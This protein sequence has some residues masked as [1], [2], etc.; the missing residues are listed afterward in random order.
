MGIYATGRAVPVFLS[1]I[2]VEKV[3]TFFKHNHLLIN[4]LVGALFLLMSLF[5]FKNFLEALP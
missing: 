4:R 3:S 2:V 5:F 1:G